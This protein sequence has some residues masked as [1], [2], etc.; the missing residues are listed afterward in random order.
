MTVI[1]CGDTVREPLRPPSRPHPLRPGTMTARTA[2]LASPRQ[3]A[4]AAVPGETVRAL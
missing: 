2:S 1:D 3:R 4:G